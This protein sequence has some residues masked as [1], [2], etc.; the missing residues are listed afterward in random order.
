MPYTGYAVRLYM[1]GEDIGAFSSATLDWH[2]GNVFKAGDG[3]RYEIVDIL[4]IPEDI[5]SEFLQVWSVV[6]LELAEPD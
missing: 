6:P 3:N 4:D 1:D 5:E 2:P